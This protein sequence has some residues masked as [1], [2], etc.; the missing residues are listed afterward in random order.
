MIGL[1]FGSLL[2]RAIEAA[3]AMLGIVGRYP[4]QCAMIAALCLA[5]W[6]WR[7]KNEALAERDVAIAGRASDRAAYVT[8]QKEAAAKAIAAKIATEARWRAQSKEADLAHATALESARS[9]VDRYANA[10]RVRQD[11]GGSC[12]GPVA[13]T[14]TGGPGVPPEM[15]EDTGM[16]G[17]SRTDL[18]DLADWVAFGVSAHNDAVD[19]IIAGD[20]VPG[21]GF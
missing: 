8:A 18:Q 11:V 3:T 2:K 12:S 9:A 6:Q 10:N 13:A 4:W 15:P 5:G 7:G 14:E 20:A 16:V 1:F 21:V 19:R 17:L